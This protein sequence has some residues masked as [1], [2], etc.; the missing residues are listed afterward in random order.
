MK[1]ETRDFK[2][3]I[4]MRADDNA[5]LPKRI[6][7]LGSPAFKEGRAETEFELWPGAFERV[8]PGAFDKTLANDEIVST[9][10]HDFNQLLG[11]T[12]SGTLHLRADEDGLHFEVDP[13]DTTI[14]SDVSKMIERGDVA[15]ASIMFSI[16]EG[17]E[18][19]RRDEDLGIDIR[20][21]HELRLHEV[22]PVVQPAFAGTS[23]DVR[24]RWEAM[25][26]KPEQRSHEL[27][28]AK[29]YLDCLDMQIF[30]V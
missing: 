14:F 11:R 21:L 28:K 30:A 3:K 16:P 2:T 19:F 17:G 9:F 15:G 26:V 25:Q 24:S 6:T 12:S 5:D 1:T 23:A 18:T 7:G 8:M 13:A 10:N 27:E 4:E 22:G 29:I 20:E